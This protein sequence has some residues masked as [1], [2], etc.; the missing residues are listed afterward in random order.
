M[1]TELVD[2]IEGLHTEYNG[3]ECW[4][5]NELMKVLGIDSLTEYRKIMFEAMN[6]CAFSGINCREHFAMEIGD[7]FVTDYGLNR[8]LKSIHNNIDGLAWARDM[9]EMYE[10]GRSKF[11]DSRTD[12]NDYFLFSGDKVRFLHEIGKSRGLTGTVCEVMFH[13]F[14]ALAVFVGNTQVFVNRNDV[15]LVERKRKE[16]K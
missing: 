11:P 2:K 3:V 8:I 16:E 10:P 1:N 4:S 7:T 14:D 15:E 6:R 13:A 12:A 9:F 5:V